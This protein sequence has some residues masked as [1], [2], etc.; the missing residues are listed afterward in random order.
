MKTRIIY[1]LC[2]LAVISIVGLSIYDLSQTP[3]PTI[4]ARNNPVAANPSGGEVLGVEDFVTHEVIFT[5]QSYQPTAL[6]IKQGDSV[7]FVNQS[8]RDFWPVL[9]DQD[10]DREFSSDQRMQP[11]QEFSFRFTAFGTWTYSDKLTAGAF[12]EIVVLP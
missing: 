11:G 8:Q 7:K 12:G 5:G 10:R 3:S 9:V 2:S 1:G 6:T 4:V